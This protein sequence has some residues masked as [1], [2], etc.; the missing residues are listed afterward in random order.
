MTYQRPER[1]NNRIR[2]VCF[3]SH[4]TKHAPGSVLASMGDTQVL[5]TASIVE[6]TPRF[7]RDKNPRQG[8]LTAEYSMLPS[9]T[10]R[11]HDREINRGKASGRTLEIQRLIGRSL[12][13][14]IDL[15]RLGEFTI[16]IDCDVLQA[17]GGTR[18]TAIS[19]GYVALVQAI[20]H[21]QYN[22]V[23]TDDPITDQI[24]AVSVGIVD[25]TAIL[26]LDYQED[27]CAETDMNVVMN[28]NAAF[29][30][31]QGTAEQ[32]PFSADQLSTLLA[33]ATQG[34]QA[35]FTH[36]RDALCPK[37]QHQEGVLS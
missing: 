24:A 1:L 25:G 17:D 31:I 4:Y 2:P 21:L 34:T 28:T 15:T 9:A 35:I 7:L 36:Q 8:W 19:G 6:G 32:R 18:T 12:R 30:E 14:C 26:D 29:I 10:H 22:K 23:I 37:P 20:Q 27:S 13:S 16:H 11:R 5:C 3:V 33:L